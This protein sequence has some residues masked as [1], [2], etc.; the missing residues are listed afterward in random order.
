MQASHTA[1]KL[2]EEVE[3]VMVQGLRRSAGLNLISFA[4]R[5][6]IGVGTFKDIL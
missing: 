3:K 2:K 6:T 1:A 4:I 5:K